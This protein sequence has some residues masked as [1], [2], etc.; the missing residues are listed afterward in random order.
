MNWLIKTLAGAVVAGVGWKFGA[1]AYEALKKQLRREP[2]KNK[3]S[4]ENGAG[5][6]QTEVVDVVEGEQ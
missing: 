6:T 3:V 2:S 5:V 4:E 1:D